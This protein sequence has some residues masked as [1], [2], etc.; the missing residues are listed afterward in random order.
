MFQANPYRQPN[1]AWFG[2]D[3]WIVDTGDIGSY[4]LSVSFQLLLFWNHLPTPTTL[5]SDFLSYCADGKSSSDSLAFPTLDA[6]IT[7]W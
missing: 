1:A 2:R 3:Y 4:D 5:L 6:I 7:D